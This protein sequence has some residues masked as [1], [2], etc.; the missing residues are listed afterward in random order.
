MKQ[1]FH[2]FFFQK[3]SWQWEEQ[4]WPCTSA[5]TIWL[6]QML[7][8]LCVHSY[9]ITL[10]TYRPPTGRQKVKVCHFSWVSLF[11]NEIPFRKHCH[12][13]CDSLIPPLIFTA[14]I[15]GDSRR[16]I[17]SS[18]TG[19]S[20]TYP[21]ASVNVST[22][23]PVRNR[24]VVENLFFKSTVSRQGFSWG[25]T[26]GQYLGF[27]VPSFLLW[28]TYASLSLISSV[29]LYVART[30]VCEKDLQYLHSWMQI[31]LK[32]HALQRD[33]CW[34]L[35]FYYVHGARVTR[36]RTASKHSPNWFNSSDLMGV[37][38]L[39]RLQ[40]GFYSLPEDLINLMQN[41]HSVTVCT[42]LLFNE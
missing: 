25:K 10:A 36:W 19:R 1:T 33:V 32:E 16:L 39:E 21:P 35:T 31:A 34:A 23:L 8:S 13:R 9:A 30:L 27:W 2:V 6:P 40:H 5:V 26:F 37:C 42:L 12:F 14:H 7:A 15:S 11:H 41:T 17:C 38:G 29:M 28:Y 20:V 18:F 3:S 24:S 4:Q 22:I